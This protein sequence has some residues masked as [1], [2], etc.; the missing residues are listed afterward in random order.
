MVI[1]KFNTYLFNKVKFQLLSLL[2]FYG[3]IEG[4]SSF[5]KRINKMKSEKG[6]VGE[7]ANLIVDMLEDGFESDNVKQNY[8][9]LTDKSDMISFLQQDRADKILSDD[10]KVDLY[11]VRGRGEVKIGKIVKYLCQLAGVA[12]VD[13]D[14]ELFVN[15]FKSSSNDN[16]EF[17]LVSG[18]DI[19]KYYNYENYAKTTGSLGSS[20]MSHEDDDF[21]DIYKENPDKIKMLILLDD[22]FDKIWGRALVW[23][24]SK[25]PCESKYLLDRVYTANDSDVI[26]FHKYAEEQGWMR[27]LNN[28]S[29]SENAV[30]FYYKGNPVYGEA[31][32]NNI[33]GEFNSYP[34]VDTMAFLTPDKKMITNLPNEEDCYLL[35]STSG[36]CETCDSCGGSVLNSCDVC[37]NKGVVDCCE[38]DGEGKRNCEDCDGE[39]KIDCPEC[40]GDKT[41]TCPECDGSGEVEGVRKMKKCPT[42]KG[43]GNVKCDECKGKGTLK[44]DECDGKGIVTCSYC[45]G[46]GKEK[47]YECDGGDLFCSDCGGGHLEL[48]KLGIKTKFN[49][50]ILK[51]K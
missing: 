10:D 12:A 42:C 7:I 48:S 49:E 37:D 21:F 46:S 14:I 15:H 6:K 34:F 5:Y 31:T 2:E 4:T 33:N 25:S 20:C 44:C 18:D 39:G 38:C 51:K 30:K 32:V 50:K 23:K 9:D 41:V 17:K 29:Y 1:K 3:E 22:K 47:C 8:F 35:H 24:L 43:S 27:K 13:K 16:R 36:Y 28:N 45:D 11:K 19:P 26:K 40:D